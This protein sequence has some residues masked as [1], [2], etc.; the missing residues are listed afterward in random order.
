MSTVN[1]LLITL[2]IVFLWLILREVNCWYW[3]VNE[4]LRLQ[5]ETNQLLKDIINQ[6]KSV[7]QIIDKAESKPKTKEKAFDLND[8]KSMELLLN[9]VKKEDK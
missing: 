7:D 5:E 2:A 9:A 6:I 8:P 3:K 1:P 4:R